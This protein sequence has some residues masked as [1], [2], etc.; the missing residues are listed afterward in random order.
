MLANIFLYLPIVL[1]NG[2]TRHAVG[3]DELRFQPEI[4]CNA[5]CEEYLQISTY[6]YPVFSQMV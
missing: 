5:A 1:P 6:I 4:I 2:V 3:Y